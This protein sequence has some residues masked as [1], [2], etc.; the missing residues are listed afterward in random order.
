MSPDRSALPEAHGIPSAAIARLPDDLER[1]GLDPHALQLS[2]RG[3]EG[4]TDVFACAWQPFGL[5]Q[6]ALVY[7]VS[8]TFT[9]LAIGLLE[10]EGRLRLDDSVGDLLGLENPNGLTVRHLLTMNTGHDADQIDALQYDVRALLNVPPAATPGTSFAY[11]S[12]ATYALSC[13]VT[14]LTGERLTDYLRPRLLDPLGIGPRWMKPARGVEQGFSGF[15]LTV[16]DVARVATMLADG[17]RYRGEQL[18]PAE[19]VTE[20]SHPWSD[21]RDPAQPDDGD[22][23]WAL[24]YGFQVWRSRVG[25]RLDGAYGQFGVVDAARGIVIAYQGSTTDTQKTLTAFWRLL[26]AVSD[27]P[28]DGDADEADDPVAASALAERAGSLD[29]WAAREALR[30]DPAV[31][32]PT[33]GWR[34]DETDTGWSLIFPETDTL[35][36]VS[37]PVGGTDWQRSTLSLPA[38]PDVGDPVVSSPPVDEATHVA[39]AARGTRDGDGILVHLVVPT[40]P[41]RMIVRADAAGSLRAH[42][43]TVPLQGPTLSALAVPEWVIG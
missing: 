9:S 36:A 30:P 17:G 24:G 35:D 7:S 22:D 23:D 1:Q 40:S 21:T 13:I 34:L 16:G 31:T 14:A 20:L 10:A 32:I 8:K 5:E 39:I 19:Y 11:N 12:D 41:H 42:W 3:E 28:R 18:V 2:R 15:H 26:D 33:D 29:S 6:P 37:I 25:F 38:P 43:H 27:V 4:W